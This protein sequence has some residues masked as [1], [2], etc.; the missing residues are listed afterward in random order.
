MFLFIC[1]SAA[2]FSLYAHLLNLSLYM[3]ICYMF[4]FVQYALCYTFFV[5]ICT[6]VTCFSLYAHLLHVSL[7][8]LSVILYLS[9]YMLICYMFLF[10]CS[11]LYC[12]FLFTSSSVTCASLYAHLLNLSLN[13]LICYMFLFTCSSVISFSSNAHLLSVPFCI[14]SSCGG[15]NVHP[16]SC[17]AGYKRQAYSTQRSV[18]RTV[19]SLACTVYIALCI[20]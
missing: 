18:L 13:M 5:L 1:L 11:L 19:N 8:M 6:S 9:L 7:Y 10:I 20:Q 3:L 17:Q 15:C 14:N 12:I 2:C 4:L 16:C